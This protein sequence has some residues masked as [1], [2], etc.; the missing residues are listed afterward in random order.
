MVAA[1]SVKSLL[2][3]KAALR[4]A[5]CYRMSLLKKIVQVLRY[6]HP[7]L[8]IALLGGYWLLWVIGTHMP[9]NILSVW[10]Y[11]WLYGEYTGEVVEPTWTIPHLDKIIHGCAYFGLAGLS[12]LA[13]SA[14]RNR[15]FRWFLI[16]AI[17]LS[18]HGVMDELT[19]ALVP[20]RYA[21]FYDWLCDTTGAVLGLSLGRWLDRHLV[22]RLT[23]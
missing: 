18:L 3:V 4:I 17:L 13:F 19:Q 1:V 6:V 12:W 7:W 14:G 2:G 8:A 5:Q 20:D 9:G 11:T 16:A 23:K 15:S 10:Y 21:D 22:S